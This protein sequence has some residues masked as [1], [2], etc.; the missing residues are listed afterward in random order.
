MHR[1]ITVTMDELRVML[2]SPSSQG[3]SWD[4]LEF[5]T[6][7][8]QGNNIQ[9]HHSLPLIAIDKLSCSVVDKMRVML[10]SLLSDIWDDVRDDNFGHL[11]IPIIVASCYQENEIKIPSRSSSKPRRHLSKAERKAFK[12]GL[13]AK[14]IEEQDPGTNDKILFKY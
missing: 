13:K 7:D 6:L 12:A 9:L 4:S 14:A 3:F 10:E 1:S 8:D 2:S 11:Q 5:T